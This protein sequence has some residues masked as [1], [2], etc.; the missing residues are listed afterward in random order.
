VFRR[1]TRES[2][3]F[4]PK[5]RKCCHQV[6]FDGHPHQRAWRPGTGG[7]SRANERGGFLDLQQPSR[8]ETGTIHPTKFVLR[9]T[10]QYLRTGRE[11]KKC[12][13]HLANTYE[14]IESWRSGKKPSHHVHNARK[15]QNQR[16]ITELRNEAGIPL[17]E[18]GRKLLGLDGWNTDQ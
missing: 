17:G 4:A 12:R 5:C 6:S 3:R 16:E 11:G 8:T 13:V 14:R 9:S 7:A 18:L 1:A 15:L 10:L 2:A